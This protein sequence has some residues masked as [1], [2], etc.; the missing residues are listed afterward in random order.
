MTLV[1]KG[2]LEEFAKKHADARSPIGAWVTEVESAAWRTP[3][4]VKQRYPSASALSGNV[5]IFNLGGNKY[6]LDVTISFNAALV[7]VNRIGTH[8]EYDRWSRR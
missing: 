5:W 6:R 8:A 3:T 2:K 7:V 4:E 1:G